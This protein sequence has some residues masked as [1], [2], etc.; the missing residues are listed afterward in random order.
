MIFVQV[1][2]ILFLLFAVSRVILR[3]R[4]RKLHPGEFIFWFLLFLIAIIGVVFPDVTTKVANLLGIGRGSD[5]IIYA[6]VATL[7]YLVFR[8]YIA[9]EDVRH[10]ITE[11]VRKIALK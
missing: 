2:L 10:E 8:L 11:L 7:F 9:V 5:L 6:S 4:D 1:F 3:F